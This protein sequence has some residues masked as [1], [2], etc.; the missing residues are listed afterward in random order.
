MA[1]PEHQ[2]EKK[3]KKQAKQCKEGP[4]KTNATKYPLILHLGNNS[5]NLCLRPE[6]GHEFHLV[7]NI[8]KNG[9]KM[10]QDGS[11]H[12]GCNGA[13]ASTE[14]GEQIT[15]GSAMLVIASNQTTNQQV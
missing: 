11:L 10:A 2:N 7:M 5:L 8:N 6:L 12:R 3:L 4:H 9:P 1:C 13:W 14:L 15:V